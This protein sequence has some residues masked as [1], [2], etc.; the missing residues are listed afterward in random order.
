MGTVI[1]NLLSQLRLS[2]SAL[3][4]KESP[5]KVLK[6]NDINYFSWFMDGGVF[7]FF[8]LEFQRNEES[9]H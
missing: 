2:P 1:N 7:E 6:T 9:E 3:V 5:P 8:R 4:E